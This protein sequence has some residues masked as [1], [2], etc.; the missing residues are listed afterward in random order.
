MLFSIAL[1]LLFNFNSSV[2]ANTRTSTFVYPKE[3]KYTVSHSDTLDAYRSDP[4]WQLMANIQY[5][6]ISAFVWNK[7]INIAAFDFTNENGLLNIIGMTKEEY[8]LQVKLNK[9]A[10]QR[11]I[12]KFS[13]TGNCNTCT[14]PVTSQLDALRTALNT[15]RSNDNIYRDFVNNSLAINTGQ[16]LASGGN[17]C[18]CGLGFYACCAVCSFA[19]EAFPLYLACCALCYNSQ[20]CHS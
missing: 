15:F 9:E 3:I 1:F 4:D 20:C 14:L 12:A 17:C 13:L 11:L 6:F 19:I 16:N 2:K 10:A 18:C 8:L 5:R 7:R